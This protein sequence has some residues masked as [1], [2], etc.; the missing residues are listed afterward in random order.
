[1]SLIFICGTALVVA[2]YGIYRQF[3]CKP[4]QAYGVYDENGD[5]GGGGDR[6]PM[7]EFTV[8]DTN[9]GAGYAEETE[10]SF[11]NKPEPVKAANPFKK[12]TNVTTNPFNQ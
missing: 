4:K 5:V 1:M 10:A 3:F 11:V 8:P 7:E 9:P 2:I 12:E 6:V